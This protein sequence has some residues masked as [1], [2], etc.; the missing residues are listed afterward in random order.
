ME[1]GPSIVK[2]R[3]LQPSNMVNDAAEA[4]PS[5]IRPRPVQP[6]NIANENTEAG[7]SNIRPRPV[8]PSNVVNKV[9]PRPSQ[10]VNVA[11]R[12][13]N[14]AANTNLGLST[15]P[16]QALKASSRD[17]ENGWDLGSSLSEPVSLHVSL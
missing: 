11:A 17:K 6:L 1:A 7:P 9:R 10:S 3:P 13:E 8:W 15:Q 16:A 14:K 5:N 2:P 4:G 12:N